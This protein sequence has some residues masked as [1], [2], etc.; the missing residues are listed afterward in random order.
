MLVIKPYRSLIDASPCT[1]STEGVSYFNHC[2]SKVVFHIVK[3]TR[4][5]VN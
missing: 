3:T 2:V 4:E 1:Y 5:R